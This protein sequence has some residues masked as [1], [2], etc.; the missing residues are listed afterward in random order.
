M[1][2]PEEL[3][4]TM[5]RLSQNLY[6]NAPTLSQFAACKAFECTEEL[7][8]HV[9]KYAVNRDIVLSTLNELGIDKNASPADGAFYV[10]VDLYEFGVTDAPALCSRLLEE[11]GVAI[12][13]GTDF[14]CP[15]T[16]YGKHRVRFSYSRS[17]EEVREGMNRF[18]NWWLENMTP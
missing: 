11:A 10:Y 9:A 6:I 13:P 7:D 16:E 17:T 4:D 5:N 15:S 14:E 12:T 18:R 8:G 3:I 1:V 2:V